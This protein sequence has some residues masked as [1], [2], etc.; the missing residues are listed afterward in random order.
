M[1]DLSNAVS[2]VATK[3]EQ[4]S[5]MAKQTVDLSKK[6]VILAGKAE[7][8]ME[9][10]MHSV[11]ETSVTINDITSQVEEI[12]KIVGVISGIADQTGILD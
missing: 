1:E 6:G 11:E 5:G 7:K 12:G 4:A 10:I 9:G 8:G 2:S 3:A